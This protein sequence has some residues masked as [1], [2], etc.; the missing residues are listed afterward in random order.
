MRRV[1]LTS[2]AIVIVCPL[3]VVLAGLAFADRG[4]VLDCSSE[5]ALW[6]SYGAMIDGDSNGNAVRLGDALMKL[7][8]P[9]LLAQGMAYSGMGNEGSM[10]AALRN[11]HGW[12]A[13]DIMAAADKA[14]ATWPMKSVGD[15]LAEAERR[16]LAELPAEAE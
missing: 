4:P 7:A 1:A 13:A 3:A 10:A 15:V 16:Q 8:F 9:D 11:Y 2:L 5:A 12:N 6:K 14:P